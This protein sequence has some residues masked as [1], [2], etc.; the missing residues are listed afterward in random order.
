MKTPKPAAGQ[1]DTAKAKRPHHSAGAPNPYA[2]KDSRHPAWGALKDI[3]HP[4][5]GVDLTVPAFPDFEKDWLEA[6]A[7]W[8]DDAKLNPKS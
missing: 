3:T 7:W 1:S 6:N 2:T 5:P 4:L 8:L